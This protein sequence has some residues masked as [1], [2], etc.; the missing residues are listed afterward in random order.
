[1]PLFFL[2]ISFCLLDGMTEC[3]AATGVKAEPVL[4]VKRTNLSELGYVVNS[5]IGLGHWSAVHDTTFQNRNVA[6]KIGCDLQ[7]EL[8]NLRRA[9]SLQIGPEF[10]QH[11]VMAAQLHSLCSTSLHA[12]PA[13]SFTEKK[14]D[15]IAMEKLGTTLLRLIETQRLAESTWIAAL[16]DVARRCFDNGLLHRDLHG[17]N[18]I[19]KLNANEFRLVDFSTSSFVADEASK[20]KIYEEW[21]TLFYQIKGNPALSRL[22]TAHVALAQAI[23]RI[24]TEWLPSRRSRYVIRNR[25]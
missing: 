14:V 19:A 11:S 8:P 7:K 21:R 2:L 23:R 6:L 24:E 13:T 9:Y 5:T 10:I 20:K 15:L 18:V 17:E 12:T 16:Y 25:R 3:V 4:C 22:P 1:M